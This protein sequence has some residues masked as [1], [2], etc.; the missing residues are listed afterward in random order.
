VK[1]T[2]NK[3]IRAIKKAFNKRFG[4]GDSIHIFKAPGRV[5]LIGEHTDYNGG[6]VLPAA[7]NMSILSAGR[8]RKDRKLNL[9]SMNF[10]NEVSISLDKI[11]NNE[12]DGW[13]NYAK[14]V[15][16]VLEREGFR[17]NGA[18]IV[19]DGNIPLEAGLSSSAAIG[20]KRLCSFSKL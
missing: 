7:I 5:N 17:L 20:K 16:W 10:P 15:A 3:R 13:A 19:F 1:I 12:D 18:D 2:I 4:R 6:L 11:E 9:K 8:K 14:G